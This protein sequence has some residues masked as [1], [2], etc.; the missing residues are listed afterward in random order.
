MF[1][2]THS[3]EGLFD[4]SWSQVDGAWLLGP[5]LSLQP[6]P[7]F[8]QACLPSASVTPHCSAA[9]LTALAAP[10]QSYPWASLL[11]SFN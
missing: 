9:H 5:A 2:Q 3:N 8:S 10:P 7:C 11:P 4:L 1:F 6:S